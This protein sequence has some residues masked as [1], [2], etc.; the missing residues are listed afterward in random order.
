[1]ILIYFILEKVSV[2]YNFLL[3]QAM[4]PLERNPWKDLENNI[5]YAPQAHDMLNDFLKIVLNA[6][7]HYLRW[8]QFQTYPFSSLEELKWWRGF[9]MTERAFMLGA[10]FNH[11]HQ[12]RPELPAGCFLYVKS[13]IKLY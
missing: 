12:E 5:K 2:D 13:Q 11:F 9:K 10:V 3:W 1:M 8:P 6:N 7:I 4:S